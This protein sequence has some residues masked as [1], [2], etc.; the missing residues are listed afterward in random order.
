MI[1]IKTRMGGVLYRSEL[2][3]DQGYA[4]AADRVRSLL[5]EG[6]DQ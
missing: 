4:D 3:C 6:D 2:G 5:P 1:E